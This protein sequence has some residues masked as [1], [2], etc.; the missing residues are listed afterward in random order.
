MVV[1]RK[2]K[3]DTP[4][5]PESGKP[6][7]PGGPES[8]RSWW[9]L[10]WAV[11]VHGVAL[12][13]SPLAATPVG[14]FFFGDGVIYLEQA[15]RLV[16][17]E[18]LMMAG[19]PLQPPLPIW[20]ATPLWWLFGEPA[21]VFLAAKLV[22]VAMSA[23]TGVLLY[24]LLAGRVPFALPLALFLPL[25][26]GE[27]ALASAWSAE[28]PYRL[29]L[30]ALLWL[31][32]RRPVV[33][34]LLHGLAASARPEHLGLALA[35]AVFFL[36]RRPARRRAALITLAVGLVALLPAVLSAHSAL[37]SYNRAHV[38][39]LPSPLP[40][41]VPVSF[42]GPL[43]FALGQREE[44]LFFARRTLPPP[45]G[46][47]A[48]LDPTWAPHHEAIVR[49]WRLGLA[50]IAARPGRFL[51]R[52]AAKVWAS[53][54]ALGHGWTLRDLPNPPEWVRLPVDVASARSPLWLWLSLGLAALGT[55]VLRR[56][57]QLLAVG[58]LLLGYRL[59][60]AVAF[61]PYLRST[62]IVWPFLLLLVAA[63]TVA[64][65]PQRLR[66]FW[67]WV[68]AALALVHL[69]MALAEPDYR[70]SGERDDAGE[71]IDDRPVTIRIG[72]GP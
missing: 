32:W 20:L 72:E 43:N 64:L 31:G 36:W 66:R 6:A 2:P 13:A 25:G 9:V 68:L 49:G 3:Q 19:L 33:S 65:V 21:A 40:E 30:V 27:L 44:E 56:Q 57:R 51:A 39:E 53:L 28:V 69:G 16:V 67:P 22:T 5:A 71:I 50:E 58:A 52:G 35:L 11:L 60:V 24:R 63:G 7:Q 41:W 47:P 12:A 14:L 55:W 17:G 54:G 38:G 42:G 18:P 1:R 37:A 4:S 23:A 10:L 46:R 26:F 34:G 29:L 61:F 70:L 48:E 8:G 15:R 62:M 59:L 45:P